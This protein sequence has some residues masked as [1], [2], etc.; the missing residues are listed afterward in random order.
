MNGGNKFQYL[1]EPAFGP[2]SFFTNAFS[3]GIR[4]ANPP[5]H[6]RHEWRAGSEAFGHNYGDSFARTGAESI[7]R[8]SASVLLHEDPRYRRSEST[9]VPGRLAHALAFTVVDR[10]DRG[11]PTLAISNF[12][13]AAANGFIGNAYLP[14][15]FDNVTHAGQRSAIAFGRLAGGNIAEEFAPEL[16]LLLKKLHVPHIR[17]PPV[18]WTGDK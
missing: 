15:G 5:S 11:H 6:Y 4:M 13:G 16:G 3:A 9:S 8:F 2:R 7:G 14:P 1:V 10:T 12:T 18:W 17:L